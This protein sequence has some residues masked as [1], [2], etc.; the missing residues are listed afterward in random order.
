MTHNDTPAIPRFEFTNNT[1][2]NL[3]GTLIE[4]NKRVIAC[5]TEQVSEKKTYAGFVV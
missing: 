5:E 1:F 4:M 3:G 2:E